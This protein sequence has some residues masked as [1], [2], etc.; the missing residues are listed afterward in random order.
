MP[1]CASFGPIVHLEPPLR[2]GSAV[3]VDVQDE[4]RVRVHEMK[5]VNRAF[6][7]DLSA[8]VVDA[9]DRVMGVGGRGGQS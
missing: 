7:G 8:A 6:D 9:R 1:I 2:G 4:K 5:R 3:T